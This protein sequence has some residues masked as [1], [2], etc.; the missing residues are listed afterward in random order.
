[1]PNMYYSYF[2]LVLMKKCKD[3]SLA[4]TT[5]GTYKCTLLAWDYQTIKAKG[6]TTLVLDQTNQK[7]GKIDILVANLTEDMAPNKAKLKQQ[8]SAA[9]PNSWDKGF[10]AVIVSP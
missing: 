4:T 1:M 7:W 2:I 9:C 3:K 8:I 5:T 6:A 10:V